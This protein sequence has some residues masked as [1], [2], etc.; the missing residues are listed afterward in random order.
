MTKSTKGTALV[1]GASQ[2]IGRAIALELGGLGFDVAVHY[3]S[4]AGAAAQ[5]VDE[6][7]G[8]GGRAAAFSADLAQEESVDALFA[9]AEAALGPVTLL[10]NN[11]STFEKDDIGDMSRA[12]WD[13]HI[14]PNLRAPLRLTQL[15][16]T[17]LPQKTSGNVINLIDQRVLKLTPQFLSYTVSKAALWTL[18]QTLAQALAPRIRVNAIAPGP[19][20][21]NARQS[22]EDFARQVAATPLERGAGLEE[23][24]GAVGFILDSPSLTGQMIALDGGQHLAWQTPDVTGITE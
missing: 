20:L 8:R 3:R 11:A 4:S 16:A 12:S 14:E 9:E 21:R 5:V 10:V 13:A 23:I 6:I 19:T 17:A 1:T 22:E 15:M 7:K 18:T 24:T 2:R